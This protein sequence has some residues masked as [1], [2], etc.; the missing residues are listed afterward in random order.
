MEKIISSSS[1]KDTSSIHFETRKGTPIRNAQSLK[2]SRFQQS[3]F[4]EYSRYD[5]LAVRTQPT[6]YYNCHGMTFGSRRVE[7]ISSKEIDKILTEDDY[8]EIDPKKE[9]ILPGDVIMYFSEGDFEHSGI[10]LNVPSKNDYIK[11]P[12][13]CSKWGCW[14][15]VIHYANNCP[16]DFSQTKYYRI[17]K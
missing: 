9:N 13:V 6:G 17:K 8:E 12:V 15:E 3:Q 10:V 2:I 5:V 11:I 7:I 16:Y 1:Q 4:S 14:S